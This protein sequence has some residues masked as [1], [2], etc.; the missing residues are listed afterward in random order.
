MARRVAHAKPHIVRY[1]AKDFRCY[2]CLSRPR[3]K[4][5]KPALLPKSYEPGKVV[6]VDVVYLSSSDKRETFPALNMIDWGTGYQMV[7][8]LK[9]VKSILRG[10][11]V[12]VCGGDT[13]LS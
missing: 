1:V 5:A 2:A 10:G 4:P 12:F 13:P 6:G 8:R 9:D 3:P 7:E 11:H